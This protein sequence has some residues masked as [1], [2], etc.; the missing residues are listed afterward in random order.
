MSKTKTIVNEVDDSG[1]NSLKDL[2][3]GRLLIPRGPTSLSFNCF[4]C[5]FPPKKKQTNNT[6]YCNLLIKTQNTA[7]Q[8]EAESLP[9]FVVAA[10]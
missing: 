9:L 5:F 2:P 10:V 1:G 4:W 3:A 6:V 7:S 8:L